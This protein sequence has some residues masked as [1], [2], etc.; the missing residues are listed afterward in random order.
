VIFD[1]TKTVITQSMDE[2]WD[3]LL[4]AVGKVADGAAIDADYT[5]GTCLPSIP[6]P[7]QCKPHHQ[8]ASRRP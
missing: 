1:C 6:P 3:M 4:A 2:I 5:S 8:L 7:V